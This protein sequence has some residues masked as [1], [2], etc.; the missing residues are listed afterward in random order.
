MAHELIPELFSGKEGFIPDFFQGKEGFIPD[1]FQGKEGFIPDYLQSKFSSPL[2]LFQTPQG[3]AKGK[4]LQ[5]QYP[6]FLALG[7]PENQKNQGFVGG[8]NEFLF[9]KAEG[10]P[11]LPPHEK[12]FLDGVGLGLVE[13]NVL[14]VG[15]LLVGYLLVREKI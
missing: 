10:V 12:G 14:I 3:I 2:E 1:F 9:G 4:Q 15:A 11:L 6:A 7:P 8:V 13:K 5:L